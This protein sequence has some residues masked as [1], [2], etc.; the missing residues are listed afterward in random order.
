MA[1]IKPAYPCAREIVSI[2]GSYR[3]VHP[4]AV[5]RINFA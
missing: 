4:D 5:I 1:S 2:P 3:F